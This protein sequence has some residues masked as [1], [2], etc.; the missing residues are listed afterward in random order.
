MGGMKKVSTLGPIVKANGRRASFAAALVLSG[1]VLVGCGGDEEEAA[2]PTTAPAGTQAPAARTTTASPA[3]SPEASPIG[4][5]VASPAASPVASPEG[6][7]VAGLDAETGGASDGVA[8]VPTSAR[9]PEA[10]GA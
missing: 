6:S 4:S 9:M 8:A 3:A 10:P 5:P 7:P 2:Q 1:L